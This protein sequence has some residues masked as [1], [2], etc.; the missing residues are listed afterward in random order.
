MHASIA[1]L[2]VE[3]FAAMAESLP[4]L[5]AH[6]YSEA[7]FA[8]E[9]IGYWRKAGQRASVRSANVCRWRWASR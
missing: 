9:A 2:L 4:E 3:R 1:E 5:V 6:H 8:A 7:G